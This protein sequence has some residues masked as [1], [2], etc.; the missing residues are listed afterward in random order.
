[1]PSGHEAGDVVDPNGIAPTV[2]LNHGYP[3]LIIEYAKDNTPPLREVIP[4]NIGKDGVCGCITAHYHKVG[5]SDLDPT[6]QLP[7]PAV[8]EI[9]YEK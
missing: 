5:W 7:H 4:L 2:R 3:V 8:L 9:W 6:C 1:M